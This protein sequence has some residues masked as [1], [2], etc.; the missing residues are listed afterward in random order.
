MRRPREVD[1]SIAG[2]SP[3]GHADLKRRRPID[4]PARSG[5]DADTAETPAIQR[6]CDGAG[7]SHAAALLEPISSSPR[8]SPVGRCTLD[9]TEERLTVV[10]AADPGDAPRL[11]KV[12]EEHLRFAFRETLEFD[13][14]EPGQGGQ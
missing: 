3:N 2:P 10:A 4:W 6:L 11:Q 14:T 12:V 5:E 13:W 9:A 1:G 7:R 8:L